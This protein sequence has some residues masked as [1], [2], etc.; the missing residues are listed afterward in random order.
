LGLLGIL[1]Y[2]VI[3]SGKESIHWNKGS[4]TA[5]DPCSVPQIN[6]GIEICAALDEKAW[7]EAPLLELRYEVR[8][9][10][11]VPSPVRRYSIVHPEFGCWL[12]PIRGAKFTTA[13]FTQTDWTRIFRTGKTIYSLRELMRLSGL[14]ISS[15]R[16]AAQRLVQKGLLLKLGKELYAFVRAYPKT[17]AQH[18]DRFVRFKKVWK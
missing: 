7:E 17:V 14:P 9:G 16:R 11:N 18:I 6:S 5:E 13:A 2:P 4:G 15:M 1:L 12:Y 8:P 10:N 3:T